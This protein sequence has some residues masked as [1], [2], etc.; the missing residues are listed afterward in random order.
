MTKKFE[1]GVLLIAYNNGKIDYEK[2]A[3]VAA[4]CV[5]MHMRYNHVT[6]LTDLPTYEALKLELSPEQ[7]GETFD[8]IIIDN[9]KHEHN[10]RTHRDSPWTEFTTQFNN[11]NKHSIFQKT[12]YERTLMIDVD[13]LVGNDTLDAIFESDS[14]VAMYKNAISVR[15]YKPRIWEQKLHPDGID[16][17]W[18]TAVYWRS[19]SDV[20]RLFFDLWEHVKENYTY[21]KWLYKFPG[22]L[23]RTDYSVSIATHILNGHGTGNVIHELP[24]KTMRFSEQIDDIVKFNEINDIMLLCPDPVELWKNIVSRIKNENVHVMNK[25]AI[26]RHYGTIKEMIYE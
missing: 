10:T 6:L 18:S 8:H 3:I 11:K 1:A 9:V 14:D 16:M 22:V 21:Y 15:N 23:Y 5:K 7:A 17:W 12:P 2:L 20:A 25:M 24:G 19:D 26:L 4:R 13:Y